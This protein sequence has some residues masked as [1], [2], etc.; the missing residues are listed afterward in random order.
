MLT[1]AE[2]DERVRLWIHD[3]YVVDQWTSLA[4][5]SPSGTVWLAAGAAAEM[6]MQYA[7]KTGAS[8]G[9]NFTCFTGTKVRILRLRRV[10]S[11]SQVEIRVADA[12]ACV[13]REPLLAAAAC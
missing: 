7:A 6:T 12:G 5:T 4:S 9:T 3:E 13:E 10:F 8:A 1:H 11:L 2:S